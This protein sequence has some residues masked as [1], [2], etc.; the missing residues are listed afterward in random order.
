MW[1]TA[2]VSNPLIVA[3]RGESEVKSESGVRVSRDSKGVGIQ[4]ES[5]VIE[6]R[7]RVSQKESRE[8]G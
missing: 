4:R 2:S 6:S 3:S 7:V 8:S 1:G 5:E